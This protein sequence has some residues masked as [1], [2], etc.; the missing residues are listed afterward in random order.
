MFSK[1]NHDSRGATHPGIH[2]PSTIFECFSSRIHDSNGAAHPR[3]HFRNSIFQCLPNK[4]HH[5]S[6]GPPKKTPPRH[7]FFNVS[8]TKSMIPWAR[9]IQEDASHI[10]FFQCVPSRIHDS[11]GT[12]HLGIHFPNTI[13]PMHSRQNPCPRGR[14]LS[15]KTFLKHNFLNASQVKFM[16]PGAR[17]TME[18]IS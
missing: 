8:Q 2:F 10:P 4:M 15:R 14:G 16:I 13:F 17:P 18:D 9:P 3:R 5:D 1:K 12:A 7:H 6:R 11:R